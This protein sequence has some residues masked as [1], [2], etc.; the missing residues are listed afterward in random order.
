MILLCNVCDFV[1]YTYM[2]SLGMWTFSVILNIFSVSYETCDLGLRPSPALQASETE[3]G[4]VLRTPWL[5]LTLCTLL[6]LI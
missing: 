2:V 6:Y 4:T 1:F 5:C 3:T